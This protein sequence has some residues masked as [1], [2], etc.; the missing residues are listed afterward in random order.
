MSRSVNN[1]WLNRF[2]WLTALATLALIGL[3]GVVT[4]K[5]VGMS[6]PDW[7]TTYGYNMFFFPVSKWVGGIFYEN[8]HRLIASVVGLLTGSL[9]LWLY[10]RKSRPVSRWTGTFLIAGGG[11][12]IGASSAHKQDG[13][14]LTALGL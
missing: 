2:A 9:T 11:L 13:I 1:P 8:T 3:G 5:G 10:G 14:V 6:V 12:I 7:P 4:S